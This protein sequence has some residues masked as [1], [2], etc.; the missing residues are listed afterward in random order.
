VVD[1]KSLPPITDNQFNLIDASTKQDIRTTD[2]SVLDHI[3][4]AFLQ[5]AIET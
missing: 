3:L 4:K 5:D 2:A 1:I